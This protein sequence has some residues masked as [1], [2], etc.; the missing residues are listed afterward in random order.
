MDIYLYYLF[1]QQLVVLQ[2]TLQHELITTFS[3]ITHELVTTFNYYN[4]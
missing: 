4:N 1:V 2:T 3:V